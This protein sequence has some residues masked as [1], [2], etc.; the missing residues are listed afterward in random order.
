MRITVSGRSM[1]GPVILGPYLE[2]QVKK[3]DH[4]DSVSCI[5]VSNRNKWCMYSSSHDGVVKIW[6]LRKNLCL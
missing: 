3:L 2:K 1:S 4:K 5:A 6:D